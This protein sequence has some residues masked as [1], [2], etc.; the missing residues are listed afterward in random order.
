MGAFPQE[1]LRAPQRPIRPSWEELLQRNYSRSYDLFHDILWEYILRYDRYG[2]WRSHKN[3]SWNELKTLWTMA[4]NVPIVF[5]RA[6]LIND[7]NSFLPVWFSWTYT[8][9]GILSII[10]RGYGKNN[11]CRSLSERET[12]MGCPILPF[13][14]QA[15]VKKTAAKA[16][17]KVPPT[18]RVTWKMVNLTGTCLKVWTSIL[19]HIC[20]GHFL[21]LLTAMKKHD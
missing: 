15:D 5:W 7:E 10:L 6:F 14:S 21:D 11:L 20:C 16:Q 17:P 18:R 12:T 2:F 4:M 3:S 19:W 13:E 8:Q 1:K 9:Y